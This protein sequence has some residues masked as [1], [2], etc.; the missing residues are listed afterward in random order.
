MRYRAPPNG[1]KTEFS[2]WDFGNSSIVHSVTLQ[3]D[4]GNETVVLSLE[5]AALKMTGEKSP[6]NKSISIFFFKSNVQ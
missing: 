5:K 2:S 3:K 4:K 1:T 6:N